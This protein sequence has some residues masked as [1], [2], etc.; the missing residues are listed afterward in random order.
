M[1]FKVANCNF[2]K[3]FWASKLPANK[4]EAKMIYLNLRIMSYK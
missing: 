3:V 1:C 4:I 2:E